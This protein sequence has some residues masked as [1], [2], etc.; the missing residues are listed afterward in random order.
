MYQHAVK[1]A[2]L[3]EGGEVGD[4]CSSISLSLSSSMNIFRFSIAGGL[5]AL[6][7]LAV[8]LVLVKASILVVCLRLEITK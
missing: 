1:S 4:P 5:S 2:D 7:C 3:V 6:H 8:S